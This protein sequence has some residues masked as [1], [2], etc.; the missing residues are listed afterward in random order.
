MIKI[1][2]LAIPTAS[3]AIAYRAVAGDRQSEGSTA[4]EALDALMTQL[5]EDEKGTLIIVQSFRPDRFFTQAQ[6]Q[7][8]AE[9]MARW[10]EDRDAGRSLPAFEQAELEALIEEEVRASGRRTAA[11][12]DD[13]AR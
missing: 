6:Q 13:L 11:L 5:S 7:R 9:L 10:R 3:G 2:I 1:A 12:L 8:L 4:G